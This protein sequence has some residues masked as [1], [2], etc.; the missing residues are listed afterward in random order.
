MAGHFTMTQVMFYMLIA[1]MVFVVPV[2]SETFASTVVKTSTAVLFM[3]GAIS[4]IVS[5]VPILAQANAAAGTIRDIEAALE[6]ASRPALPAREPIRA[7][8]EIA[9][10]DVIFQHHDAHDNATFAV[11]PVNLVLHAGETVFV[12]GGN[13]SGKTTLIRLLTGLYR[14]TTGTIEIDGRA[15]DEQNLAAYR[16]MFA[17]VFS[18]FYLFRRLFGLMDATQERIDALLHRL[19][20]EDKTRV[21]DGVFETL[22]LSGGQRKRVALLVA[23]LEDKPIVVLDEWAADQDPIFRKKFYEELLP[24]LKRQGK[25]IIAITHD[26]HYFHVADRQLKMEYGRLVADVE[27]AR[28]V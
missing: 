18:D 20:I 6:Q 2:F 23:I 4:G 26:D 21:N 24:E 22:D 13:G 25:T 27:G 19:E 10:R 15:V 11:G 17:A 12:T 5:S 14:P 3:F 8:R 16:D 28:R 9:F 7:F 1:T